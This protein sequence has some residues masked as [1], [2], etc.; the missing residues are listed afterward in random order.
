MGTPEKR[1]QHEAA[2]PLGNILCC[3]H[4]VLW[5]PSTAARQASWSR[6]WQRP[7][8]K[9]TSPRWPARKTSTKQQQRIHR[10]PWWKSRDCCHCWHRWFRRRTCRPACSQLCWRSLWKIVSNLCLPLVN[11]TNPTHSSCLESLYTLSLYDE[12]S[13]AVEE[14]VGEHRLITRQCLPPPPQKHSCRCLHN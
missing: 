9:A 10:T 5:C 12:L 1:Y 13:A 8:R 14:G 3:S 2:P 11:Q 6:S 4:S 7:T